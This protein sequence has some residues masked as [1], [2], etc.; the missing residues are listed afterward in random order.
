MV[1]GMLAMGNLRMYPISFNEN[2][3]KALTSSTSE[4]KTLLKINIVIF[5]PLVQW[6]GVSAS[7]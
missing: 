4:I 6:F 7:P 5:C 2:M 3:Q 1:I